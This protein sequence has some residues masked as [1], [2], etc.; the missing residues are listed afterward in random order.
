MEADPEA[1]PPGEPPDDSASPGP[2]PAGSAGRLIDLAQVALA[3]TACALVWGLLLAYL[4]S[5]PRTADLFWHVAS[6]R[7]FLEQGG[8]V[9]VDPFAHTTAGRTWVLQAWVFQLLVGS[10][11]ALGGLPLVRACAAGL[12]LAILAAAAALLR[13]AGA[14]PAAALAVLTLLGVGSWLRVTEV[15]PHLL[16]ILFFFV[17]ARGLYFVREPVSRRRLALFCG[18]QV[19]WVNCHAVGLLGFLFY[20][21]AVLSERL[22]AALQRR[23]GDEVPQPRLP[24]AGVP[25][26]FAAT[27]ASP[28]HLLLWSYAFMD[29]GVAKLITDE[30]GRYDPFTLTF[31]PR[32]LPV[33]LVVAWCVIATALA[34]V[35]RLLWRPRQ[36][37]SELD[38]RLLGFGLVGAAAGFY[39]LRFSWLWFFPLLTL[40]ALPRSSRPE[41]ALHAALP[42]LALGLGLLFVDQSPRRLDLR[43]FMGSRASPEFPRAAC[44][45]FLAAELEGNLFNHYTF[46]GYLI[47]RLYPRA[48][49]FVDGRT[50][51]HKENLDRYFRLCVAAPPKRERLLAEAGVDVFVGSLQLYGLMDDA[52]GWV[53][54]Y[55]DPLTTLH[56]PRGSANLTRIT[57]FYRERG[58]PFDPERGLPPPRR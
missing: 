23:L 43:E 47:Y 48:K 11:D 51:I 14:K 28:N 54:V 44:D 10:C 37:L 9:S 8:L 13:Q 15:R 27:L 20:V 6:G 17:F 31:D 34:L 32:H 21:G 50:F 41:R 39:A 35:G 53:C 56:V 3:L 42:A 25:L 16:S 49:V 57:R 22:G 58:L 26:L 46:G 33:T 4:A 1:P 45:L 19:L 18:L 29:L 36:T 2:A 55:R 7:Y 12:G 5:P 40:A 24:L 52:P 30:W 38:P